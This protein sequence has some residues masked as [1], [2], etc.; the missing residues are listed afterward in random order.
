MNTH[1]YQKPGNAY[2]SLDLRDLLDARDAYHLHLMNH[3]HVVASAVG[4]YRIR[5]ADS[6]PEAD[7]TV[8][9]K[10]TGKRTLANSEVRPYSWPAI[11]L[12]VDKWV[13]ADEFG[14]GGRYDPDQMVPRTLYL[15]DGRKVPVCVIQVEQVHETDQNVPEVRFPLNN[16]G[17]GNPVLA[18][19]QGR[20]HL[21]TITCLAT[22]GHRTYALTNRHVAGDAGELLFSKLNGQKMP[23]GRSS[24]KQL[25][26][27]PFAEVYRE[28][29]GKGT[30]LNLDAGLIEID[31]LNSWTA[32]VHGI[33][34]I[35][36]LADLSSANLSLSL[37]GCRVVGVGA[38]SGRMEGEISALLYRYKSVG[39]FE[40]LAD[41]LIGPRTG[42][43]PGKAGKRSAAGDEF[44]TRPGDSG[45]LW[46]L[47][48]VAP[49]RPAGSKD[50]EPRP[51]FRPFAMQW[52]SQVFD[53]AEATSYALATSLGSV[54]RLLDLDLVRGWNIDQTDTWGSIGHFSIAASVAACVTDRS[55]KTL[56]TKNAALISPSKDD[57]RS[58]EFKGMGTAKFVPL[59]DVPDM[60]WKQRVAKQG[61]ARAMEGPNHFAD[62]DQARDADGKTLL[63]L[64]L[65]ED[66]IDPKKW[67]AFYDTVKDILSGDKIAMKHRGLLPFR[68]WQIFDA[69]VELVE[70]G[71]VAEFVCAAGVLTHYIGDACQPLHISYLHDGDPEH[72]QTHTVHHVKGKKKGTTEDIVSALGSGVHSAYEDDMV[73]AH[74]DDILKGLEATHPVKASDLITS[75]SG[76]AKATIAMMR[77]VFQRI[78]PR[79]IVQFY[80]DSDAK[81]K[82]LA[83]DMWHEF[84]KG[85][86][87]CM[88]D[89][90]H[91]L[92]VLWQS[93]WVQ[94]DAHHNIP[95]AA[96]PAVTKD[97][98]MKICQNPDFLPSLQINKISTVL[99]K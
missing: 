17:G 30:F 38:V 75:G 9:H 16:I 27:L 28:W 40:Y 58:S 99:K 14:K 37:V 84:G 13:D 73:S 4:K 56:M 10:G 48:P 33:G 71:K 45:A 36:P 54:C 83:E 91:L 12:F 49:T 59:A 35:G 80:I 77:K 46:L 6:W 88:K 95:A 52:G 7:G 31:D 65:D 92:A 86:V 74:R 64:T 8:K 50:P 82:Q 3:P 61:F 93:A 1:A 18:E 5:T 89:G 23:I 22:D 69:M 26:R 62:M 96:L 57:I 25:T 43:E 11:L 98:A 67:N 39:G 85:T 68:V 32:Q 21:A 41:F 81:P 29:S 60:Y 44:L 55:L 15:P 2:D 42:L 87:T 78:P 47:D 94:G 76:A 70:A 34:T 72:P 63:D 19:V 90:V 51:E 79:Q 24:G 97:H 53:Q 20:N 66:F